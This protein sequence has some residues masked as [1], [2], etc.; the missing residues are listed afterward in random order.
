MSVLILYTNNQS[1]ITP[2]YK[3]FVLKFNGQCTLLADQGG[4]G[5]EWDNVVQGV[6][7]EEHG[8]GMPLG[9]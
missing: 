4:H 6:E 2:L 7:L 9:E 8:E 3:E 1:Y 5:G